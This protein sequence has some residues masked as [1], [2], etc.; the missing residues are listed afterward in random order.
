M[1]PALSRFIQSR[2]RIL[3]PPTAWPE[4][5]LP[6]YL[7]TR[8]AITDPKGK[9]LAVSRDRSVLKQAPA[10]ATDRDAFESAKTSH[11]KSGIRAWDFGNLPESIPVKGAH[12]KEWTAFPALVPDEKNQPCVHLRLFLDKHRAET[13]HRD[14]VRTLCTLLLAKDLKFLKKALRLPD[15]YIE[16]AAYAEG[17]ASLETRLFNSTVSAL[18]EKNIRNRSEFEALLESAPPELFKTGETT[19]AAA[20]TVL[21]AIH[22]TRTTLYDLEKKSPGNHHVQSLISEI[23]RDLAALVPGSF[24]TLYKT[25]R[26]THLVRYVRAMAV[27]AQ[28]GVVDFAKDRKW[29]EQITPY[30]A[31]LGRLL[32]SLTSETS[33]AKRNAI[34]TFFWM[35][36]EY[37]VS[38]FAQEIKTD[39]PISSKRLDKK[40]LEIESLF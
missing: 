9:V 23:R 30:T 37:K 20:L 1:L 32:G 33:D 36:E 40:L 16:K 29:L 35:L 24:V 14:G 25:R 38:V 10:S 22:D 13:L 31:A 26:L 21:D 2:F 34:E 28:K 5:T 11:E 15:A 27:R 4:E 19:L 8:I 6:E 12:G 39:G 7:K 17:A 18:F 3:I